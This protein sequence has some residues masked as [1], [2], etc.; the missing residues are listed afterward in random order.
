[1]VMNH[2]RRAPEAVLGLI[3]DGIARSPDAHGAIEEVVAVDEQVI[4][5]GDVGM[6][7]QPGLPAAPPS[8]EAP[9]P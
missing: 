2:G 3:L 9:K 4:H 5:R 8:C 7:M 6:T 1:M